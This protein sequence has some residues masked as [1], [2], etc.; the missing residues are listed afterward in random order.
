MV[1]AMKLFEKIFR[2]LFVIS[3]PL[4]LL[5]FSLA[6]GFNSK[7]IF[8][9]GFNKYDVSRATGLSSDN[10]NKI[11]GSWIEYID[12]TQEYWDIKIEQNG[13]SFTL[14]TSDEQMHF[15]DVKALVW[16]DYKVLLITLLLIFGYIFY[17]FRRKT[18]DSQRWLAA[19][20]V[21]G[22]CISLGLILLLGVASFLDF[23]SLFLQLHYLIFSNSYWYA[24]GYMLNLFPGGFWYDAAFFCI[25]LMAALTFLIGGSGI[26][27]L[28]KTRGSQSS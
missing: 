20:V 27:F 28:K 12:S 25:G 4:F 17:Q 14:F 5:T 9:Y 16:L 8:D 21:T 26:I 24:E 3:L 13:K 22:C 15:K 23:D 10:L 11:S 6:C 2:V 19:E 7:W 18:F 1:K